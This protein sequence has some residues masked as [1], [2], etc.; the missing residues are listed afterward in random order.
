MLMMCRL[1]SGFRSQ[2]SD[3]RARSKHSLHRRIV[4]LALA[5]SASAAAFGADRV[6]EDP[7]RAIIQRAPPV[8][9]LK[10]AGVATAAPTSAP[11]IREVSLALDIG[12]TDSSIYNPATQRLDRV[13]LRSY[14]SVGTD[15][16]IPFVAPTIEVS[17]GETVRITLDNQLPPQKDCTPQSI[18][19][20]HCFNSTN[21]H[22][23][24]LWVSPSGNSDNVLL[25]LR[26][27]VSFQ[28][29]YNIPADHP[30]GTF[31]YHPHLHGST[32]LQVSSGM[33]G[34]LL[35]RG[36]RLPSPDRTGDIDTLL[37]EESGAP[38]RERI[39][40]LQQ[41]QYACRD[42]D[43]NIKVRKNSDG[44]V[45][46]WVCDPGDVGGIEQYD[47]FGAPSNWV[48]SNRYTSVNGIILPTFDGAFTGRIERWR[49]IHAGVRN[50]IALQFRMLRPG[51]PRFDKLRVAEQQSWIDRNC[52]GPVLPQWEI[53]TDGLTHDRIINK[54]VNTLQPGYRS[55]VL[56]VFPEPGDYCVI[57]AA[58][59]ADATVDSRAKSRQ[60]LGQVKVL[61]GAGV[62]PEGIQGHLAA[63][64]GAAADRFMPADMIPRVK[65][66]LDDGLKLS[67]FVPH[68]D[69]PDEEVSGSQQLTFNVETPDLRFTIDDHPYDPKSSRTL[70]LGGVDEWQLTSRN[71]GHPFHIH[72]N[73]FQV[74]RILDPSGNDVSESGE[75]NDPQY[76]RLKGSWKDTL[77]VKKDY[78]VFV[79]TRY[80]RYIGE[81]V[82]HCHILDHEDQGMMQNV[83]VLLPDGQGGTISGHHP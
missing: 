19:T 49:V 45:T 63:R 67:A 44:K 37:R 15:P 6:V 54:K 46:A 78:K 48:D 35:V 82:L 76:A 27:G 41:V 68:P 14:R 21:L 29:E 69:I 33:A 24:G 7:T 34:A 55:D 5:A 77:F 1:E 8:R 60:L 51:A 32:A 38:L 42:K 13:R 17:P 56:M 81:Y 9:I 26:P 74:A 39:V 4:C 61:P 40:L 30:S 64:L 59:P 83:R 66:D 43:G 53:A 80:Q 52:T 18:N 47:Q 73:P 57:D 79:R 23:H 28:Y 58:A 22:A 50:S 25:T 16:K 36:S 10:Q 75:S 62:P 3:H 20:P 72:V 11:S 70:V 2:D 31:W 65:S 71:G 12:Y